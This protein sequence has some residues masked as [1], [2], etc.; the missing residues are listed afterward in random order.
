MAQ[1]LCSQISAASWVMME[2]RK[3][4]LGISLC[5]SLIS[6]SAYRSS[7]G[8]ERL[9]V[10]SSSEPHILRTVLSCSLSLGPEALTVNL[11]PAPSSTLNS[12]VFLVV[13]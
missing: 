4:K 10:A 13:K 5:P 7:S 8:V 6:S 9:G 11:L 2:G 3:Q 1:T 12:S